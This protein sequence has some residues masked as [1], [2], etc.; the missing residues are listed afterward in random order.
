M[1]EY[2]LWF[3]A[4]WAV[5]KWGWPKMVSGAKRVWTWFAGSPD[6]PDHWG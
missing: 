2:V 5:G 1:I 6:Q 4:G 3:A